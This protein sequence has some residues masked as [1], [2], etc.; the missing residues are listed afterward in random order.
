MLGLEWAFDI[1]NTAL[2]IVKVTIVF[3]EEYFII[4]FGATN[5][6]TNVYYAIEIY[7]Y[8]RDANIV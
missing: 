7:I 5:K 8:G 1:Q 2:N 3:V 6:K 4:F